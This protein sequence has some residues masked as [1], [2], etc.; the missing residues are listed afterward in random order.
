[1]SILYLL[2]AVSFAFI[3]EAM[4]ARG[5]QP[6]GQHLS[7]NNNILPSHFIWRKHIARQ[8]DHRYNPDAKERFTWIGAEL[9]TL[10][11]I[12]IPPVTGNTVGDS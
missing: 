2:A 4:V 5:G 12:L 1:M 7:A 9:L 3:L 6:S 8:N 10:Q 11:R